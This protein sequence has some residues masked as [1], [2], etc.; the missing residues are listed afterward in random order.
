MYLGQ[1]SATKNVA[2]AGVVLPDQS[3]Y[4][5]PHMGTLKH[6]HHTQVLKLIL[7]AM[8]DNEKE[9]KVRKFSETCG[10]YLGY[11]SSPRTWAPSSMSTMRRSS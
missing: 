8:T 6:E 10:V 1:R 2:K 11:G 5:H 9:P 3:K 4:P 7:K